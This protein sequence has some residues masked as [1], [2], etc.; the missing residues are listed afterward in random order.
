MFDFLLEMKFEIFL[1]EEL[2][3]FLITFHLLVLT[4]GVIRETAGRKENE[5]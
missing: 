4:V 5:D 1:K 3:E 2:N